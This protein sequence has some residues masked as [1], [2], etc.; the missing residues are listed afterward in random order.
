MAS[1]VMLSCDRQ[2]RSP[3]RL[4]PCFSAA[5]LMAERSEQQCMLGSSTLIGYQ[6]LARIITSQR[7]Y[8][9]CSAHVVPIEPSAAHQESEEKKIPNAAFLLS[10]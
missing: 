5:E 9:Q 7:A 4:S 2:G 8:K 6:P 3:S 1:L 10:S